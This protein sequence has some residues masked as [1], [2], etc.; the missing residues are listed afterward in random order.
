MLGCIEGSDSPLKEF[1]ML[2]WLT[3]LG[4]SV[5][6]PLVAFTLLGLWLQK[7]F[8]LGTW[9]VLCSCALGFISAVS[10]FRHSLKMMEQ[11]D[12]SSSRKKDPPPVSF[13]DHE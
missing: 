8:S 4:I 7:R 9:I 13:N 2:I 12:K 10:S 1:N 3:Q 5:I 6:A 11:M